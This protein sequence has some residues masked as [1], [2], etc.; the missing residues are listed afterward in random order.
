MVFYIK[1]ICI[2]NNFVF[3]KKIWSIFFWVI[4]IEDGGDVE[5]PIGSD[6]CTVPLCGVVRLH[7]HLQQGLDE[8]S[9]FPIWYVKTS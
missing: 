9:W 7:C 6:R 5:Q 2:A 4:S 1:V 3:M 8:Q